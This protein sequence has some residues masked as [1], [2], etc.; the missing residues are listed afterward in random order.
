M[1]KNCNLLIPRSPELTSKVQE[2]PSAFKI[3]NPEHQ[4]LKFLNFFEMFV[5]FGGA[6]CPPGSGSGTSRPKSMRIGPPIFILYLNVLGGNY[7]AV[8]RQ[9]G[10][11]AHLPPQH[12]QFP[13]EAAE[14]VRHLH[15]GTGIHNSTAV[16]TREHDF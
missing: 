3:E 10:P 13:A 14:R 4:N 16:Y 9:R 1:I 2:K 12:S 8:S 11:P 5:I 6:F 7:R 15:C